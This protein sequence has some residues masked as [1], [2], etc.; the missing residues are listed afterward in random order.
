MSEKLCLKWND[1]QENINN[2]FG[3]LRDTRDFVDV[4]LACEDGQQVEAHKVILAA[5]SSF[6]KDVFKKNHHPHPLIYMRGVKSEDLVA[7][8]DFLYCG[9]TN[10]CQE[11]LDSFLAIAQEIKLKG[12]MEQDE[13][14]DDTKQNIL[15]GRYEAELGFSYK[16]ESKASVALNTISFDFGDKKTESVSV[17]SGKNTRTMAIQGGDAIKDLDEQVKSMMEKSKNLVSTERKRRADICKVCGKEGE[18]ALIMNHIEANHLVGISLPCNNCEMTFR[19]RKLLRYH[20]TMHHT[21][22][23]C[24]NTK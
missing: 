22:Q 14:E 10:V 5:S 2:A 17:K 19:S 4:T 7:I 16:H 12:L 15:S 13:G 24:Q 8:L 9:E 11:N 6:F 3:S 23:P 18:G 21:S 20:K 1:F